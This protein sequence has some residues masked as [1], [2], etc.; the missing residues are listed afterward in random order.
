V[1]CI[2]V[3]IVSEDIFAEWKRQRF[4]VAKKYLVLYPSGHLMILTDVNYWSENYQSLI[5]W[6][7]RYGA[8][9]AGMTVTVPSDELLTIFLLRWS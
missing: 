5:E 7:D 6:C 9:H 2:E 4:I 8:E 3:V 1:V